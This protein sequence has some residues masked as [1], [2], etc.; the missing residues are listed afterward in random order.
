KAPI[1]YG[2]QSIVLTIAS[3]NLRSAYRTSNPYSRPIKM[4]PER[5]LPVV[6]T[7]SNQRARS[8]NP[9]SPNVGV[10]TM[11]KEKDIETRTKRAQAMIAMGLVR[12][13]GDRF[14]VGARQLKGKQGEQEIWRD[15]M[16]KVRCTCN[17]FTKAIKDD[18]H[19]R[20]EHIMA[21]KLWLTPATPEGAQTLMPAPLM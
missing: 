13:A 15:E 2:K 9:I 1:A 10:P 6:Q 17:E 11:P 21:V 8:L 19:F 7:N 5:H 20:C 12:R 18:L 3:A 14:L 16:N 4:K